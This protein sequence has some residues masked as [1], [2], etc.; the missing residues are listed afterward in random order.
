MGHYLFIFLITILTTNLY[1]EIT[2]DD[3]RNILAHNILK[4]YP[5]ADLFRLILSVPDTLTYPIEADNEMDYIKTFENRHNAFRVSDLYNL[6]K[7]VPFKKVND[8]VLKSSLRNKKT[9]YFFIPGIVGELITGNAVLTEILNKETS[10]KKSYKQYLKNYKKLHGKKLTDPVFEMSSNKIE[11]KEIEELMYAGSIDDENNDPLVKLVY[12][13]PKF[14]SMETFEAT[15]IRANKLI[16]RIEKM[17]DL[18]E[19]NENTNYDFVVIGYSQ[20][21]T[22]ALEVASQ[23]KESNSKLLS[24]LKA[25]VSYAGV[26]WGSDLADLMLKDDNSDEELILMNRQVRAFKKMINKLHTQANFFNYLPRMLENKMHILEFLHDYLSETE[27]SI[28]STNAKASFMHLMKTVMRIAL[29][30]FK[31]L[32]IGIFHYENT[33]KLKKFG[34]AVLVGLEELTTKY[35]E[36]WHRT[37][38][39]PHKGVHYYSITGVSGDLKLDQEFLKDSHA[40]MDINS[41][42]FQML[43]NQFHTIYN[44]T[45]VALNDCQV[46]MQRTRFWPKLASIQNPNQELYS[47]TFLGALGTHHWG[48]TFDFFNVSTPKTINQFKRPELILSLAEVIALDLDKIKS[49]KLYE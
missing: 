11:E 33:K 5:D 40:G 34:E 37:H 31:V 4:N 41:F 39:L 7:D 19:Q 18:I 14:L 42:D 22:V 13:F 3:F 25:V 36:N 17:M 49:T 38:V 43:H 45:G 29:V 21:G 35:M 32:D 8:E 28:K 6:S 12:F 23:L 24:K 46:S 9:I 27:E 16:R 44:N 48:I 47:E 20:G 30:E 26:I 15:Q 10:F 2:K 1:A